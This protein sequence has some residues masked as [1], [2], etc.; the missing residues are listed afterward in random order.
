M[1]FV[2]VGKINK[3]LEKFL[4]VVVDEGWL[5]VEKV[6]GKREDGK[7]VVEIMG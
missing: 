7:V 5:G 4:L 6:Y 1:W 3:D 2:V